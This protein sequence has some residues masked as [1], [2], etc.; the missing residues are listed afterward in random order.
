MPQPMPQPMPA[1]SAPQPS[2]PVY[3]PAPIVRGEVLQ[4]PPRDFRALGHAELP[5][6]AVLGQ[7]TD[8]R[9]RNEAAAV[10]AHAPEEWTGESQC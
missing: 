2:Q 1:Y 5:Q 3:Q 6:A 4:C 8:S 7:C 9:V 10:H